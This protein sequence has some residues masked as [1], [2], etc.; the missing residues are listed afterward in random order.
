MVR[1]GRG[2]GGGGGGIGGGSHGGQDGGGF[3]SKVFMFV[4]AAM[5]VV[6]VVIGASCCLVVNSGAFSGECSTGDCTVDAPQGFRV[7]VG[8]TILLI[9]HTCGGYTS[10][11]R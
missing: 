11:W 2:L 10:V 4:V 6:S 8:F 9:R 3:D 1:H 7:T 5:V